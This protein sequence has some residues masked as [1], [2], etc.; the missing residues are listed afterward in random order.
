MPPPRGEV[1]P[2]ALV[3]GRLQHLRPFVPEPL[4]D[5]YLFVSQSA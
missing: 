1:T 3:R 5:L 4:A 2:A